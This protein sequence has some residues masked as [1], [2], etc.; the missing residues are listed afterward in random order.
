MP[1]E[2]Y[3]KTEKFIYMDSDMLC[4]GDLKELWD[5]R[6]DGNIA[7]A[8]GDLAGMAEYA[9]KEIAFAGD[10]YFNAGMMFINVSAWNE[11]AISD[12]A[13]ARLRA[14]CD[15][16]YLDQDLLNLLL[17]GRVKFIPSKWNVI[18]NLVFM[19]QPLDGDTRLIHFAGTAKPW[20]EWAGECALTEKYR[21]FWRATL[22]QDE[23]L[24]QPLTY[25]QAK[26]MYRKHKLMGNFGKAAKW[27]AA[28]TVRKL[29]KK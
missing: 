23:P 13:V 3:G 1:V 9:K 16:K 7:M 4:T 25:K 26:Y 2:L 11:A 10:K 24:Q 17:C 28:Y 29:K 5:A 27:Y 14:G 21:E 6:F 8:A 15:Y 20:Q 22:W 18:Y 12:K 19:R